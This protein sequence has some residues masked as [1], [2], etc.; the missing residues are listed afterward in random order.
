MTFRAHSS[1]MVGHGVAKYVSDGGCYRQEA[2]V[3]G[4]INCLNPFFHATVV[5]F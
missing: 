2:A 1:C 5:K 4:D 3:E